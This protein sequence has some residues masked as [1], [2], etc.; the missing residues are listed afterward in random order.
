[1][2]R[3]IDRA[4]N[5]DVAGGQ[6]RHRGV[7]D[8]ADEADGD[9]RR[10]RDVGEVEDSVGGQRQRH[11]ARR[12]KRAVGAGAAAA[13]RLCQRRIRRYHAK[14]DCDGSGGE[15]AHDRLPGEGAHCTT[16]TLAAVP[17]GLDDAVGVTICTTRAPLA[18]L[19]ETLT[20]AVAVV[21][22]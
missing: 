15:P 22:S 8:V 4:R 20:W 21:P 16:K 1:R 3:H 13:E 10:N 6:Y 19:A 9:T 18:A 17:A 12:S 14:A 2:R 5:R 11:V 7:P